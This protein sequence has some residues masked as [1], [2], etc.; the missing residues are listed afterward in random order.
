MQTKKPGQDNKDQNNFQENKSQEQQNDQAQSKDDVHNET[1]D[2]AQGQENQSA[3]D[4][5]IAKIKSLEIQIDE[6]KD[7]LVRS[8]AESENLRKR[9]VADLEKASKYAIS[10]FAGDLVPV[11]ENFYLA[12]Q[13]APKE[14]IAK[15]DLVKNFVEGLLMTQK[16]ILKSFE[17]HKIQRVNPEGEKFDHNFHQAISK[18]EDKEKESGDIIQVIQAGYIIEDRLL[19]P[20]LVVVVA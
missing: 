20:A 9:G 15:N 17:K 19:R 18:I 8:Y 5:Y 13:N 11:V 16:E 2:G 10:N 12:V 3:A 1:Q 4:L 14:E 6:Y 7:K